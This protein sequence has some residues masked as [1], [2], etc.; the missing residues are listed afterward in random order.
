MKIC[1][2]YE[3]FTPEFA[4]HVDVKKV[5]KRWLLDSACSKHLTGCKKDLVNFHKFVREDEFE[6]VTLADKSVVRAEGKGCLNLY[7]TDLHG[8]KVPVTFS[9]VLYVPGIERLISI[10]QLTEH[11]GVQVN[12]QNKLAILNIQGRQFAF[13]NK[14]G[15][16]YK[17]NL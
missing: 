14:I 9:D 7:L 17:M 4:L 3:G 6:Y 1:D 13:G 12:F 10:S 16:L 5:E 11:E 8:N 15:K 2:E